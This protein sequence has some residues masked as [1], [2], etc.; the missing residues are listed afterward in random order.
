MAYTLLDDTSDNASITSPSRVNRVQ[1]VNNDSG[2]AVLSGDSES[3]GIYRRYGKRCLDVIAVLLLAPIVLP[4]VLVAWMVTRRDGHSAFY[5]QTRVGMDGREFKC[6]KIRTMINN[7]D[8]ELGRILREDPE[9]AREWRENQKLAN[10]PR[11]TRWG[12]ALRRTSIDELPQLWNVLCGDMSL[13][14]PRPF[15][16]DQRAMYDECSPTK[17]YY[18]LRPGLSGLWQVECRNAGTFADRVAF[19]EAYEASLTLGGD[20]S[21]GLRTVMVVLNATGK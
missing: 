9:L 8:E 17:A 12:S 11:V 14:G 19:D 6:W 10:D 21:I 7:A 20:L 4:V 16:P 5:A 15:T 13:I 18:R 3:F 1:P 2:N